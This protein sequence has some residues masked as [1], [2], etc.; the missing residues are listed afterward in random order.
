M[1]R[2]H[3]KDKQQTHQGSAPRHPNAPPDPQPPPTA[4]GLHPNPIQGG[5]QRGWGW[6]HA[7][8]LGDTGQSHLLL[9]AGRRV[10]RRV[11]GLPQR[12]PL[13]T[14]VKRDDGLDGVVW[15][16]QGG[17][18]GGWQRIPAQQPQPKA[19]PRPPPSDSTLVM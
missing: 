7:S 11:L 6:G 13:P 18:R 19:P 1:W 14:S 2:L 12:H 16:E 9:A 8:L 15:G 10:A 4:E 5:A 17:H 3:C